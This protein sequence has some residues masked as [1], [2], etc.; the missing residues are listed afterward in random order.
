MTTS[1]INDYVIRILSE[2]S[3]GLELFFMDGSLPSVI[4]VLPLPC[5]SLQVTFTG[6]SVFSGNL[7][8]VCSSNHIL[9]K[10]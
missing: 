2:L 10:V 5:H 7:L 1:L 4:C 6:T 9:S 8:A 3:P